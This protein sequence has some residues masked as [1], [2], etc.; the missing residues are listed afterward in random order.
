MTFLGV[1]DQIAILGTAAKCGILLGLA[2]DK[3]FLPLVMDI[4]PGQWAQMDVDCER[5]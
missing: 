2:D 3:V 1:L 5:S 4:V